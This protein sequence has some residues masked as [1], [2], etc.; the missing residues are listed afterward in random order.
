MTVDPAVLQALA[1]LLSDATSGLPVV[2]MA[3][4]RGW[5]G[6]T[7][8]EMDNILAELREDDLVPAVRAAAYRLA[9]R[10]VATHRP[11]GTDHAD[12]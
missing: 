7:C 10:E 8:D 12:A 2:A 4:E 11:G 1:E 3:V 6:R 9:A 5:G